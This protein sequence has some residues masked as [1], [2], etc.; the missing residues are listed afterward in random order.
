[1]LRCLEMPLRCQLDPSMTPTWPSLGHPE[2]QSD[3]YFTMVFEHFMFLTFI[4][5]RRVMSPHGAQHGPNMAP[6]WPQ[7]RPK[8]AFQIDGGT[9][10]FGFDVGK[11]WGTGLGPSWD[12]SW[13]PLG[14]LLGPSWAIL[15]H[16]GAILG[17][18]WA[19]LGYLRAILV[20][21]GAILGPSWAIL[22]HLGPSWITFSMQR[23]TFGR[24]L[25]IRKP[26]S[27]IMCRAFCILEPQ[28]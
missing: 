14:P 21:S 19:I 10:C 12:P 6:R 24:K 5:L 25:A 26:L 16:L 2:G 11:P 1:M 13:A 28:R 20:P 7:N 3:L 27:L 8:S 15:G 4:V 17:P 23:D 22:G 9:A 18:S